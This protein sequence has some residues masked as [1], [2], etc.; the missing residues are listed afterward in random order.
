MASGAKEPNRWDGGIPI[1]G[2]TAVHA[3]QQMPAGCLIKSFRT[4]RGYECVR[5]WEGVTKDAKTAS[6]G[7]IRVAG[8]EPPNRIK[9]SVDSIARACRGLQVLDPSAERLTFQTLTDSPEAK[10]P[11]HNRLDPPEM[12]ITGSLDA[13]CEALVNDRQVPN[14]LTFAMNTLRVWRSSGQHDW[15]GVKVGRFFRYRVGD[16]SAWLA[17]QERCHT[18]PGR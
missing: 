11:R 2:L 7:A 5:R 8:L 9:A 10:T 17:K 1:A 6:C 15:P 12:G 13:S 14:S 3:R 18:E 16:L 4:E